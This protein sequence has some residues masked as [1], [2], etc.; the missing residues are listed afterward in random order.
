M[1]FFRFY[2]H[3]NIL[4]H[5]V[6]SVGITLVIFLIACRREKDMPP[7]PTLTDVSPDSAFVGDTVR[8]TGTGFST[9]L[10]D[11]VI[12]FD[13][14]EAFALSATATELSV[15]VPR[16]AV[17]GSVT[18]GITLEGKPSNGI[19][20]KVRARTPVAITQITPTSGYFGQEV[21]FTVTGLT[22]KDF[23]ENG[24]AEIYFASDQG[25][26]Q[27]ATIAKATAKTPTTTEIQV[28]VPSGSQTGPV[29][30]S[31]RA[32][33]NEEGEQIPGPQFT[34][35]PP[36][37]YITSFSPVSGAI[38][39]I[40]TI[41]GKNFYPTITKVSLSEVNLPVSQVNDVGTQLKLTLPSGI[42]A[43]EYPLVVSNEGQS[44]TA[45]SITKLTVTALATGSKFLYYLQ[46]INIFR[47]TI[48]SKDGE[49]Q[50]KADQ[51]IT[52]SSIGT[53]QVQDMEIDTT[54]NQIYWTDRGSQLIYKRNLDGSGETY[55]LNFGFDPGAGT[56][57]GLAV[58]NN[59]LYWADVSTNQIKQANTD[60][61]N[62]KI[63][64]DASSTIYD[65][66]VAGN[67]VY[68]TEGDNKQ[69]FRGSISGGN[70]KETLFT[71][72]DGLARPL[73]LKIDTKNGKIYITDNPSATDTS[74]DRIVVGNINGSGALTT[75]FDNK[76]G[77]ENPW[78]LTLDIDR[79]KIYWRNRGSGKGALRRGNV[80]EKTGD[81]KFEIKNLD[82]IGFGIALQALE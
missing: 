11:N 33:V 39:T 17:S 51:L 23:S 67:Y 64:F 20:F 25:E 74:K 71:S 58:A 3:S 78:G 70:T 7:V 61:S 13:S 5:T 65:V 49:L 37:P 28:I 45:T 62:T 24:K 32:G 9:D 54:T 18:V 10:I 55:S 57:V 63:L 2:K 44:T 73:G 35:K 1:S 50:I 14:V 15:R 31:L 22:P 72:T 30:V 66:E 56:P 59:K 77:V 19:P 16:G 48:S 4:T 21:T 41:S 8:I 46:D 27:A 29:M 26:P 76:D 36:V 42:P 38:G 52:G 43:G 81:T 69:V 12:L 53:P 34:L 40:I 80:K 82:S 6:W 47:A 79:N 60:G 68:W 75:V